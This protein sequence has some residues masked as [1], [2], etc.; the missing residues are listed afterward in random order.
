[1]TSRYLWVLVTIGVVT[2]ADPANSQH[3]GPDD[4]LAT[5]MI[6]ALPSEPGNDAFAAL[7]EI[8]Q[9]LSDDPETDWNR[10]DIGAVRR[11]LADMDALVKGAVVEATQLQHGLEMRVALDGRA[12]EAASRMVPA[13]SRVLA[14]ET[15]WSSDI[16]ARED[17]LVWA[18]V[19]STEADGTR[20]QALG[21]FGLMATGD[22][23]R[24]HHLALARG[25]RN[26]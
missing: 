10:V 4:H 14:A 5:S 16:V 6:Q 13:H 22:H 15:G 2:A 1:M 19:G 8:V 26:P 25:R 18:V 3:T 24:A 11:H 17:H 7:S 23:H 12:G 20:I 21:F 9:I